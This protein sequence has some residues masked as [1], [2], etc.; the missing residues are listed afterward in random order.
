MNEQHVRALVFDYGGVLMRTVDRRPRQEIEREFDLAPGDVYDLVFNSPHWDEVQHGLMDGDAFWT[1]VGEE[2]GLDADQLEAFQWSFWSGDRL[3]EELVGL[4]RHLRGKGYRTGLL[5][6]APPDMEDYIVEL[7]LVDAFDVTVFSGD[8][9]VTKPEPEIYDLT[10]ERLEVDAEQAIFVDDTPVNVAAARDLGLRATRFRGLEPLRVWLRNEGVCVPEPDLDP[11]EDLRAV[12]FDWG[13]VMEELPSEAD[14]MAWE[15]RLALAPGA[16]KEVL[17]GDAWRRL[18]IGA[19]SDE[20]YVHR[21]AAELGFSDR[22][23]A[24]DFFQAFYTSDRLNREVVRAARALRKTHRVGLLSNAFPGQ[25]ET[26]RERYG[27]DVHTAFDVYVNSA[28]VGVSKPDP[29]IYELTL[30]RLRVEPRQTIF[31]DDSLSNVDIARELSV[32]ALQFVDPQ[33]SLPHLEALL[34]HPIGAS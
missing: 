30:R 18:A 28:D 25:A 13:G 26:I 14:V 15:G 8:E 23:S 3:D 12:I 19:I 10:L 31:L 20:D 11:V 5:S 4:I 9:G 21:V 24:L 6:N 7:G 22:E 32:H 33:T 16:L 34:G 29:S 17:W 1:G 2:L 27:L